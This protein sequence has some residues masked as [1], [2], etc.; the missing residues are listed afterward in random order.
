MALRGYL[1]GAALISGLGREVVDGVTVG[2]GAAVAG[3]R[4]GVAALATLWGVA[5][6]GRGAGG[7]VADT[8]RFVAGA[9]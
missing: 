8:T 9:T 3:A 6:A 5:A 2:R 7:G 4:G 1:T